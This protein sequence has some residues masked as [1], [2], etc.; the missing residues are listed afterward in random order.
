[1]VCS[2]NRFVPPDLIIFVNEAVFGAEFLLVKNY[3][4]NIAVFAVLAPAWF[5]D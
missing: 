1:M 2:F 4:Y 5:V 3:C